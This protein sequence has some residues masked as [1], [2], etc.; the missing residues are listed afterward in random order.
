MYIEHAL[1]TILEPVIEGVSKL[2]QTAQ[3]G[4]IS[5][6]TTAFCDALKNTILKQKIKFRYV[7]RYLNKICVRFS[8]V[9]PRGHVMQV[10]CKQ[11]HINDIQSLLF[12]YFDNGLKK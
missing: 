5:M 4:A 7:W 10:K 1:E 6:A 12:Y 8:F 3:L 2:K 9:A 11:I